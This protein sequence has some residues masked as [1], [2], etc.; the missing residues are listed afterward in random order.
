M[1]TASPFVAIARPDS[2]KIQ[3]RQPPATR[4]RRDALPLLE[5]RTA[6]HAHRG[7]PTST[8]MLRQ[9]ARHALA[10]PTH[11]DR[12]PRVRRALPDGTMT[13]TTPRRHV[14]RVA[15]VL[16]P[17]GAGQRAL[18]ALPER[19]TTMRAQRQTVKCA[20]SDTHPH[21]ERHAPLARRIFTTTMAAQ[22]PRALSCSFPSS[23]SLCP[24][25]F[26]KR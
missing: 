7:L 19:L 4:A 9:N 6:S 17:V 24:E 1:E 20:K 11:Q 14:Q 3:L 25:T 5:R 26:K 23:S 10:V 15:K 13:T 8:A 18:P 22:R 2:S 21:R 16:S 12:E